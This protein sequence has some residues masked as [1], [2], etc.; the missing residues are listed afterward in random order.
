MVKLFY[1]YSHKDETL[2]DALETHLAILKRQE[3]L[4]DWH[5]RKILPGRDWESEIDAHIDEADVILLLVSPDFIASDYCY[6]KELS[7]ALK[8]HESGQAE[9]VP[10]ILRPVDWT[11]APFS[12]LQALPRDGKPVTTWANAD[13]AWLDTENGIR[14][15]IEGISTKRTAVA[16]Q[17]ANPVSL[18]NLM[19]EEFSRIESIFEGKSEISGA[20][21]GFN[22]LDR[23]IDGI[24][25]GDIL[26]IAGRPSMGKTDLALNIAQQFALESS[27]SVV[28]FS[29]RKAPDQVLR[30][31]LAYESKVPSSR[32]IRGL[33]RDS[34]WPKLTRA[35]GALSEIPIFI[36]GSTRLTDADISLRVSK[37]KE[38]HG[39]GLI[40]I[41]GIEHVS[42][43]QKHS[44]RSSEVGSIIT[45]IKSIARDQKIPVV[46]TESTARE[47]Q[48]HRDKRPIPRDL[49]EWETLASD[50]AN[51]V[52]FLYRDEVYNVDSPNKGTTEVIVAKNDYGPV[53]FVRLAY[54][55]E[56]CSFEDIAGK[57][58]R[59]S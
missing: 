17:Q 30:R 14:K 58:D 57:Q 16:S 4:E 26:V 13:E 1:S 19:K 59:Q 38:A 40:V 32:I 35:V 36:D 44:T 18:M 33:L 53:T 52:I 11:G 2:R 12:K 3:L 29:M 27:S 45:M 47:R 21:T 15:T 24:H 51:V 56:Y 6:G 42:S 22:G 46:V 48:L 39:L 9:V 25:R 8:R 37:L 34:D 28:Y 5:D 23:I 7:R 50:A 54:F 49:D 55:P 20:S 43:A 41:D 31:L 10:V